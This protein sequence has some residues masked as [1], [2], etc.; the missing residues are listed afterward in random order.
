MALTAKMKR[1]AEEYTVDLNATQAAVRSGYSQATA[2]SV[3]HENLKKPEIAE[4]IDQLLE[5][6]SIRTRITADRV[7]E[8]WWDLANAD[9]NELAQLRRL[10]CRNCNGDDHKFQW[11]DEAEYKRACENAVAEAKAAS[12]EK[13]EDVDPLIPSDEG[14]YGFDKLFDPHPNCPKCH[15][16]G[17]LDLHM[18]DTRKVSTPARRL[19]AGIKQTQAGIEIK[20]RDQDKAL[21][22][23]ARHL[24]MFTDKVE[25]SGEV[26]LSFEDQLRGL[27]QK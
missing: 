7:L 11:V 15:G 20:F 12:I 8:R 19:F 9:P 17:V 16:E 6:R 13:G 5:E 4:Y 2:G 25:H 3:G 26:M 21:E 27:I 18:A 24:G 14:G 1:F 10:N 23:V 22:N